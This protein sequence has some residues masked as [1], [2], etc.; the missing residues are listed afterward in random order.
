MP[1]TL[2]V[3]G[4]TNWD[5]P[6]DTALL[7]LQSQAVAAQT[8]ANS[9]ITS[10]A[11]KVAVDA[12]VFNVKD[13]GAIGNNSTDDTTAI[14]TTI[15]L[16]ATNGGIVYFP[17]ATYRISATLNIASN[18]TFLGTGFGS[19][20]NQVSTSSDVFVGTDLSHITFDSL[21]ITGPGSGTGIG[22]HLN[23]STNTTTVRP[24]IRNIFIQGMGG[25]AINISAPVFGR[26]SDTSAFSCGGW[27]FN[28]FGVTA[29]ASSMTIIDCYANA[30]TSGG[31][32]LFKASACSVIASYSLSNVIGYLVDTSTNIVLNAC[33]G[34]TCGTGVKVNAGSGNMILGYY[35]NNNTGIAI[36]ITGSSATASI[37]HAF[38]NAPNGSATHFI[39]VDSGS[40]AT[41]IGYTNVTSNLF[42]G[43]VLTLDNGSTGGM[44]IPGAVMI[45]NGINSA[46]AVNGTITGQQL[47]SAIGQDTGTS[48]YR[49]TVTGDTIARYAV[50]CDG[51]ISWGPGGSS[52]RDTTLARTGAGIL[53]VTQ[54]SLAVSTA[55]SGLQIKEG[56]NAKMGTAT[57]SAGSV[58]VS[59][60]AVT[61]NSRI[62]LTGQNSS[63][64]AGALG[65]TARTAGTSFTITSTSGTD[66]RLVAW[67]IVEPA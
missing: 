9:A 26:I 59:T 12:L 19:V 53:G 43:T 24:I 5:G 32:R 58:T 34:D 11:S 6:L 49:A 21:K 42:N 2:P 3:T 35:S 13:H 17:A 54:G 38:D 56:T 45:T 61:A 60:T 8:T 67:F 25:D 46:L 7:N 62:F 30:C 29:L 27:G 36:Q 4:S 39:Q 52:S 10:I 48:A 44:T 15:N 22:I 64:T 65:V 66:T 33:F 23:I 16:A 63:G 1:I 51:S 14:Q 20:I 50:G 57:L 41:L 40:Y 31:Y 37:E 18:V 55:G 28:L 47:I